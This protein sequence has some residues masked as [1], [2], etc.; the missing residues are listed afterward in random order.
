[1][2]TDFAKLERSCVSVADVRCLTL[3]GWGGL[4]AAQDWE[5][6]MGDRGAATAWKWEMSWLRDRLDIW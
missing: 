6:W 2:W 1:M 4:F 5:V 3:S